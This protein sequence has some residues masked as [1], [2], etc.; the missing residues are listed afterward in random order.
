MFKTAPHGAFLSGP[1]LSVGG[2]LF[3]ITALTYHGH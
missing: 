2:G 1:R 3:R